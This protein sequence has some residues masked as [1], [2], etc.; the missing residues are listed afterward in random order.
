MGANYCKKCK[1][2]GKIYWYGMDIKCNKCDGTE[3]N[4]EPVHLRPLPPPPPPD[5]HC[6]CTKPLHNDPL[7]ADILER[8]IR[9]YEKGFVCKLYSS[10]DK[11]YNSIAEVKRELFN[12]NVELDKKG[13]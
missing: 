2:Q 8:L 3:F 6:C 1:G 7:M 11:S 13:Y 5:R 9:A 4:P 12:L 10:Q